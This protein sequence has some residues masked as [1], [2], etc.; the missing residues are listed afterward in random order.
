[1]EPVEFVGAQDF[2]KGPRR[3]AQAV[4]GD[5]SACQRFMAFPIFKV[6][7]MTFKA[8]VGFA[9]RFGDVLKHITTGRLSVDGALTISTRSGRLVSR[10]EAQPT[11]SSEP[12]ALRSHNRQR[13][14]GYLQA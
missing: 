2:K 8:E 6:P 12:I 10:R 3:G 1:L 14:V 4:N 9:K 7:W 5:Q 11:V 13:Q